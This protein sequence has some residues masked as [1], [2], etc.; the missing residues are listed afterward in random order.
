MITVFYEGQG[1]KHKMVLKIFFFRIFEII[2]VRFVVAIC[3]LGHD[4]ERYCV[5]NCLQHQQEI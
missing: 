2:F 5:F 4:V 1:L 3:D